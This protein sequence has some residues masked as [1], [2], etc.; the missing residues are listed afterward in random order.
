MNRR[1]F[2]SF[3]GSAGIAVT[4]SPV[5][6]K[7]APLTAQ[8]EKL[9]RKVSPL[10]KRVADNVAF[11]QIGGHEDAYQITLTWKDGSSDIFQMFPDL[12]KQ[13]ETFG[14]SQDPKDP[15][16]HGRLKRLGH[17]GADAIELETF[18]LDM[19]IPRYSIESNTQGTLERLDAIN[20]A[21][22][23]V[24]ASWREVSYS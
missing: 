10:I 16:Y 2:L 17:N 1:N 9:T 12:Q 4:L 23:T 8:P 14:K 22:P 20:A 18:Q 13:V 24:R 15:P 6:A 5:L 19:D 11:C 7:A 21:L 3:L